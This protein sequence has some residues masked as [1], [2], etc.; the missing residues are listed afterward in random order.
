MNLIW[1]TQHG[2]YLWKDYLPLYF[3]QKRR[4]CKEMIHTWRAIIIS[5]TYF[6]HVWLIIPQS[7]GSR[8][9]QFFAPK[10]QQIFSI[11]LKPKNKICMKKL[12]FEYSVRVDFEV[13]RI[14]CSR[15]MTKITIL[16]SSGQ[17]LQLHSLVRFIVFLFF[18]FSSLSTCILLLFFLSLIN[19]WSVII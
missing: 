17:F 4:E 12:Q 16:P 10:P 5:Y 2:Y 9:T 8:E 18:L 7:S 6:R 3:V 1:M 13:Y 19:G 14:T 11:C 15:D